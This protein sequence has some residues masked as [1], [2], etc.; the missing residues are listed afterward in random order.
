MHQINRCLLFCVKHSNQ[1]TF[2]KSRIPSRSI[3]T[4]KVSNDK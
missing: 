1:L 4:E 3:T 2:A